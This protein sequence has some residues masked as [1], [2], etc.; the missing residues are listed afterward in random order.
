[1]KPTEAIDLMT[2]ARRLTAA[3]KPT[4]VVTINDTIM[5]TVR[6]E[7]PS[8]APHDEAELF[9]CWRGSFRKGRA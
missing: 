4:D 8:L 1:M 7:V 3:S 2:I 6:L 9:L 5:R